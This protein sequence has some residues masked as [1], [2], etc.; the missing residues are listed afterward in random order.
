MKRIAMLALGLML[1]VPATVQASKLDVKSAVVME[2]GSGRILYEQNADM[3]IAPASVTKIMTM[4]LIFEE[5]EAGRATLDEQVSVSKKAAAQS[6]S[7]MHLKAK[8]RVTVR[9]LLQG[10]AVASGNDACIAAAEHF[11]GVPEFVARMNRKAADL[12]M[13]STHFVNPN[14]LPA[15]GQLTTARDMLKLSTA[16]LRRFPKSLNYHSQKTMTHNRCEVRNANKL[17]GE[18]DGVDG[19]KTGFVA[20]S[21]FNIVATAKRGERRV[22]AVVMGA[23]NPKIR[24]EETETV[25]EAAFE[26]LQETRH[27]AEH[28]R[29]EP[30]PIAPAPFREAAPVA[31]AIPTGWEYRGRIEP[32]AHSE[33]RAHAFEGDVR[34]VSAPVFTQS[35]RSVAVRSEGAF[36]LQAGSHKSKGMA[37]GQAHE[38]KRRGL[39][40]WVKTVDLGS[41]GVW[42]RVF[43]GKFSSQKDA[44]DFK[45][46][47]RIRALD[48]ALVARIDA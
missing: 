26:K 3:P 37:E 16:Y 1:A 11:G 29:V 20:S 14:G 27:V 48:Q 44:E 13:Q 8:E 39:D 32:A 19:I 21:G 46:R 45:L 43:V 22:I 9:D 17:L 31:Q 42:T 2:Y 34:S 35:S 10:M 47:S 4:F 12:G 6:G 30:A 18:C 15:K 25:L 41:K 36:A 38:L 40:A 23:Q 7:K 5:I 33:R 24:L 28:R